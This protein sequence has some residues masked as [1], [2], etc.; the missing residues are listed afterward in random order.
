MN[1]AKAD[2]RDMTIREYFAA[3]KACPG[4]CNGC[5]WEGIACDLVDATEGIEKAY[6]R[7]LMAM[8]TKLME[9]HLNES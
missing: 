7:P 5:Q 3:L 8:A 1:A 4:R 2:P 9:E 6:M